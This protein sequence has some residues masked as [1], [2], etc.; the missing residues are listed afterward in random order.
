MLTPFTQ[1]RKRNGKKKKKKK[2][3]KKR[4]GKR[5]RDQKPSRAHE[6]ATRDKNT[7]YTT[8]WPLVG[9]VPDLLSI[10]SGCNDGSGNG[11]HEQTN[12]NKW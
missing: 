1:L 9:T 10:F 4:K 7:P 11:M 3:R 12:S 2:K 5:K 8:C 6:Q